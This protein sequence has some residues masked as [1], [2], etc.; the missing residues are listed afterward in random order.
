MVIVTQQYT[1]HTRYINFLSSAH[2]CLAAVHP[3]DA[4]TYQNTEGYLF[5]KI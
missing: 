3:A 1:F 5:E 2:I 4:Q